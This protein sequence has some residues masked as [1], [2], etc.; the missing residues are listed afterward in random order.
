MS[1]PCVSWTSLAQYR[2]VTMARFYVQESLTARPAQGGL[3]QYTPG[4]QVGEHWK[5]VGSR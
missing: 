2:R 1:Y 3:G 4:A 5:G